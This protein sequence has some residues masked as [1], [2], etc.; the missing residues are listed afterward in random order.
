MGESLPKSQHSK[1][2]GVDGFW[3]QSM[4][5]V[6]KSSGLKGVWADDEPGAGKLWLRSRGFYFVLHL[7]LCTGILSYSF[8]L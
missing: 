3:S 2:E 5:E 6:E 7:Y 8:V 4:E 1:V